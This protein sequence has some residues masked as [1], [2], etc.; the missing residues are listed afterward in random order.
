MGTM[1]F[2]ALDPAVWRHGAV[3]VLIFHQQIFISFVDIDYWAEK[4]LA[5]GGL[6]VQHPPNEQLPNQIRCRCF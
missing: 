1:A 5:P 4:R 3:T 6:G 2:L